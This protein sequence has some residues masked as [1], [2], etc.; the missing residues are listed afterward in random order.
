MLVLVSCGMLLAP[1]AEARIKRNWTVRF[2]SAPNTN[3]FFNAINDDG[4]AVGTRVFPDGSRHGIF[5]DGRRLRDL[6]ARLGAASAIL[7]VNHRDQIVGWQSP[8][9]QAQQNNLF[10]GTDPATMPRAFFRSGS[11]LRVLPFPSIATAVNSSGLVVGSFRAADGSV[12][13]FAWNA[14]PRR[15]PRSRSAQAPGAPLGFVDRGQGTGEDVSDAQVS[16]RLRAARARC[17]RRLKGRRRRRCLERAERRLGNRVATVE[18]RG[19][20]ATFSITLNGGRTFT[21]FRTFPNVSLATVNDVGLAGG[22]AFTDGGG[23]DPILV[24]VDIFD[25]TNPRSPVRLP[26]PR[27]FD[28]TVQGVGTN[29]TTV[30]QLVNE[31][32]QPR[33]GAW[34]RNNV[35]FDPNTLPTSDQL[36]GNTF[37][38]P[39][40]PPNIVGQ[41]VGTAQTPGNQAAGFVLVPPVDSRSSPDDKL[42]NLQAAFAEL[43]SRGEAS[44]VFRGVRRAV[45]DG[46]ERRLCRELRAIPF[47]QYFSSRDNVN[48]GV[49]HLLRLQDAAREIERELSC[50]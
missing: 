48:V 3:T 7:D 16:E 11:R 40:G 6:G 33:M 30:A 14:A 49:A 44:G 47:A 35:F 34:R 46:D 41:M 4:H 18:D 15:R 29:G 43:V 19:N 28:A 42:D 20:A 22:A 10:R 27:G 8:N 24:D 37:V 1:A 39:G 26:E 2:F 32:G 17:R 25:I 38:I 13:A 36:S 5:F 45:A 23:V 21:V 31:A 12:H 50:P 9:P